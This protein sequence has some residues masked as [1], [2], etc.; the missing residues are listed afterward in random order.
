MALLVIV[1]GIFAAVPKEVWI[2]LGVLAAI[3][4]AIYLFNQNSSSSTTP[5]AEPRAFAETSGAVKGA[6]R[7]TVSTS[8]RRTE[9]SPVSVSN[10][11]ASSAYRV[12]P[13]P[14]GYGTAAWI[15]AGQSVTVAGVTL[16]GGLLYVGTKLRTLQGNNDPAIIDPSKK[17]T[18]QGDYTHRQMEYWPSYS[19]IQ[20]SARRAYLN[21]LADGRKDPEAEIG[22]VFLFFYGLERRAI[23]DGPKDEKA[24][25]E[26]PVIAT[27]LRRLLA[28]YG[29]KSHSFRRY[30]SELLSWVE[31]G[32]YSTKLYQQSV[33]E[34]P[35]S[36]E[37]PLYIRLALGQAAVD[38]VPVPA[39]LAL[40]WARLDPN[41]QLRTPAIRCAEQFSKLFEMKYKQAFGAGLVLS[42]NKTK[43]KFVYR[44]AS[45]GFIGYDAITLSFDETPDVS[46]LTAPIGKL[47]KIVEEATKELDSYSRYLG[48]NPEGA[49][50]LGG[51]LQLPATLWPE[52][53]Q[54]LMREL[55]A[56][57]ES[58]MV[59]FTFQELLTMLEASGSV[60]KDKV[61]GL[62]RAL[63]SMNIAMEPDVLGRAKTPKPD[64]T[65][66]LFPVQ[67][68]EAV[69]RTTPAYQAACLTLQL[70]SAVAVADGEMA[71]AEMRQLRNQIE[72]WTH[73]TP[74]RSCLKRGNDG[75]NE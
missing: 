57:M 28:I 43:L 34:F 65:V 14:V 53:A 73:L 52:S 5:D 10:A 48:R 31:L 44:P 58:G 32:K 33:P 8:S 62:A 13:A 40:A 54:K 2:G 66:V 49:T 17:V 47:Q 6:T 9:D 60:T 11:P 29:D 41:T 1:V 72:G 36:F 56:R 42:K 22:Y 70:A 45:S 25:A 18:P 63:E 12:P 23:L 64:E 46:V 27:E 3:G 35:Y 21:W 16:P 67:P 69:N 30:A 39:H 50:S 71:A 55:R 37:L 59:V 4:V 20:P 15:P 51:L 19:E 61:L 38:A 24:Q 74:A 26:W 68:G 7:A 75:R